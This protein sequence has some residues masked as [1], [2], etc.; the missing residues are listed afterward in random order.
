ME[1]LAPMHLLTSCLAAVVL[2]LLHVGVTP[3]R[4]SAAPGTFVYAGCSPSR[5]A[6]NTA[7]ESN[8][9]SLLAS[10]ASTASS[11]AA[12][13][14]FT[15]GVGSGAGLGKEAAAV[16]G[17]PAP[18]AA[19][20][21]L[22]QCRGD[23]SAGD[24]T[25]CV[26]DTVARVGSVCANAYAASLQSDGCLVRYGA[27]SGAADASVAYRK[28]SSGSSD[29][30]TFL[31]SRDA[32]LAQLQGEAAAT[33]SASASASGYYKVSTSGA[34][35]GVA[36][37]LGG[38]PAPDCASCLGQAVG[39]VKGTC[40][41]ALAADVYLAQCSVRYWANGDYFRASHGDSGDDVGKTVAIIIG[42]LAGLALFVVFISFLR[43]TCG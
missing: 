42:I 43:K 34:V 11:G 13:N 25:A 12:Y 10:M 8:L 23:L 7:F 37:C 2:L 16:D 35:Q 30:A 5:Y 21:G 39:Q 19:A 33:A 9:H 4:A 28:C 18:S 26:H 41:D 32:V 3:G 40:G 36:Q 22:Y 27:R 31:K 29:D 17:A 24:C 20:Y 6:P 15:S 1:Q 38:I 14:S